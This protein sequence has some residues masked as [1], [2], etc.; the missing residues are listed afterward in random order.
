[1]LSMGPATRSQSKI[2][3][4]SP[5]CNT[6]QCNLVSIH[7]WLREIST[8]PSPS[9]S[10]AKKPLQSIQPRVTAHFPSSTETTSKVPVIHWRKRKMN[11]DDTERPDLGPR[12]S[13]RIGTPRQQIGARR[14]EAEPSE[15][16]AQINQQ[17]SISQAR[18]QGQSTKGKVLS[19]THVHATD[20]DV[21]PAQSRMDLSLETNPFVS[22]L[23]ATTDTS[24]PLSSSYTVTTKTSGRSSPSKFKAP[25]RE[26][27]EYLSPAITFETIA[28]AKNHWPNHIATLWKDRISTLIHDTKVIPSGLKVRC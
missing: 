21:F 13:K 27:L 12:R 17:Q 19:T 7:N 11:Q 25:R 9:S 1:M 20:G 18:R 24:F 23:H 5:D 28:A 14:T 2:S 26:H 16:M 8:S 15:D 4:E 10:H 3:Q 6:F 22:G